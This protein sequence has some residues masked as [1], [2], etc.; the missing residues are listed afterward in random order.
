M[1]RVAIEDSA[2]TLRVVLQGR[3]VGEEAVSARSLMTRYRAG[4][5][6]VVD[7]SE[8][9]FVDA[10]GEG[11]L[12]FFGRFDA[13]FIADTSYSR[14]ICERLHL[15]VAKGELLGDRTSGPSDTTDIRGGRADGPLVND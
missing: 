7:L 12:S 2:N 11:L 5:K 6:L 8:V 14:Y 1:L 9:T 15:R 3:L 10:S 4:I 13:V